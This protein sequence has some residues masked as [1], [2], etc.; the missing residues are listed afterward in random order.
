MV[1][2][3]EIGALR[4]VPKGFVGRLDVLEIEERAETIQ[5]TV[6]IRSARILKRVQQT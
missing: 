2:L 5:T 1:I 3:I 4:I 6:L